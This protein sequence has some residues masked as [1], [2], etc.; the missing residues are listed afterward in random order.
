MMTD[1]SGSSQYFMFSG[2]TYSNEAKMDVLGV[3]GEDAD[4]AWG[5]Q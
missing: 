2:I 5:R 3:S 1:V 4:S